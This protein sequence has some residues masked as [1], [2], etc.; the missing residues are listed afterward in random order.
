MQD[1]STLA[2]LV[3]GLAERGAEREAERGGR[4]GGRGDRPAVLMLRRDAI[5]RWSYAKLGEH[6]LRLASGLRKRGVERGQSIVILAANRPQWIAACLGIIRSG[7][8]VVPL[9]VQLGDKTLKRVLK[10]SEASIVFTD[11]MQLPRLKELNAGHD[12]TLFLLDEREEDRDESGWSE[13]LDE[14]PGDLP[15]IDPD[16]HATLFYTSGTTGPPKGVPLTHANLAY[17][18]NALLKVKLV[19]EQDRLLLPLPLHHVYPFVMGMLVPIGLGLAIVLPKS[20]T[21]PEIARAL[22]E[23]EATAIIGVPRLY[24]AMYDGIVSKARAAGAIPYALFRATSGLTTFM[25]RRMKISLGKTLLRSMHRKLGPNLRLLASGGAALDPELAWRL[26]GLGWNVAVGYGLTETSPLLTLLQPGEDRFDSAGRAIPGVELRID[27]SAARQD[28][29]HEERDEAEVR[30]PL[31]VG[32]QSSPSAARST[33]R[34]SSD[35]PSAIG[36]GSPW[37]APSAV[38]SDSQEPTVRTDGEVLARGPGVF[39]G[40]RNLSKETKKALTEDGW[41]RTGDLGRIDDDGYLHLSGRASTLI[42]TEGGKNVQ[43]E[44]VEDAYAEHPRLREVGVL[45]RDHKLVALIVPEMRAFEVVENGKGA[46]VIRKRIRQAVEEQGKRLPSYWRLGDFAI[47][48]QSLPRTRLGKLQRHTLEEHYEEASRAGEQVA[49]EEGGPIPI[50]KLPEEDQALLRNPASKQVWDWLAERYPKKRL[51]PD[52]SPQLDLGVDS[53]EWVNL[54]LEIGQRSGVELTEE[55]IE[56]VETVRDLLEQVVEAAGEEPGRMKQPLENPEDVLNEEQLRWLRPLGPAM[57]VMARGMYGFDRLL[58]RAFYGI[59]V[60]GLEHLP[61]HGP[62]IIAPNHVSHLDPMA[63]AAVLPQ[64]VLRGTYWA[65]W[66]G[67]VHHNPLNRFLLRLGQGVPV[68]PSRAAVSSLAVGAAVLKHGDILV[69]FPEGERSP[70]GQLQ[71]F[72]AGV[73]VLLH[74]FNVPVVP[75]FVHGTYEAYPRSRRLPRPGRVTVVFGRALNPSDLEQEGEGD[76]P[77]D[78]IADALRKHVANL[79]RQALR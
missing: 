72:R 23:G 48:R 49:D 69:W 54:T 26:E 75:T 13:L 6:A 9:D 24:R 31:A 34:E 27:P 7:A 12:L 57:S 30:A 67:V 64:R 63:V 38:Q 17:Q 53:M 2:S 58:L 29:E 42:V 39:D 43:P 62:Y 79:R 8:V 1:R 41:F 36:G 65:A 16:E 46:A 25:R 59:R 40:Y 21:G 28:E 33:R 22:R 14:S 74:H 60:R 35:S 19:T 55:A 32:A 61:E 50:E 3:D 56:G 52:T 4:W 78:R 18:I 73:G 20:R 71:K 66:S 68:D 51:A 76:Q 77:P 10:D 5:E 44:D 37:R 47:T 70:T 15:D 45:E 11:S